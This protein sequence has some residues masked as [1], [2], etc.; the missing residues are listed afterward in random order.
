LDSGWFRDPVRDRWRTVNRCLAVAGGQR[1]KCDAPL[2]MLPTEPDYPDAHV[3]ALAD[4]YRRHPAWRA[5]AAYLADESTSAVWF[6]HRRGEPWHLE[7]GGGESWL[8]PGR[9]PDP[10]FVF[11]FTPASIH[12]LAGAGSAVGDFAVCLFELMVDPDEERRVAFRIA[13]PFSRLARR[14]YVRLLLESGPRVAAFA[15]RHGITGLRSLHRLVR[16][17]R[18]AEPFEWEEG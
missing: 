3:A 5:A 15:A 14:G 17:V 2:T 4:L 16:A 8:R 18:H 12:E 7:R 1:L 9:T 10:D 11:R 13:A 6:A